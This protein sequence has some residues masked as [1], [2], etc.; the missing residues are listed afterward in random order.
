MCV[1]DSTILLGCGHLR[2]RADTALSVETGSRLLG[3]TVARGAYGCCAASGSLGDVAH[4][5]ATLPSGSQGQSLLW[6]FVMSFLLM[7][8]VMAVATDTRAV[9]EA[10]AVAI[11]GTI[12]LDA[13]FGGPIAGASM[14]PMR[15]LGPA[16]VP[17]DL[18]ALWLYILAA[19]LGPSLGALSHQFIRS[20]P[21]LLESAVAVVVAEAAPKRRMSFV[22]RRRCSHFTWG[23]ARF[24]AT[25]YDR[26]I[27]S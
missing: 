26:P 18:H 10:A 25:D 3:R 24:C 5:G 8:V 23:V 19:V 6:G 22:S 11:G 16:L 1:G 27:L 14:N 21:S 2:V 4:V 17:G 20:E 9:G 13:M 15:S 12:G 7:F